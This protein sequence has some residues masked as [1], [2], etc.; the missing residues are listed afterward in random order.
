MIRFDLES[1]TD[2]ARLSDPMLA[3]QSLSGLVILD[4]IQRAPDLF[5]ILRVLIDRP[6]GRA[7]FLILGNASMELLKQSS[8]TL[9]GRIAFVH[10]EGFDLRELEATDADR[11][12]I[13]GSFLCIPGPRLFR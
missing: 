13:R 8:E 10:L 7:R 6:R 4:E 2:R 1:P 9:A 12:W 11:L 3:L 5:P